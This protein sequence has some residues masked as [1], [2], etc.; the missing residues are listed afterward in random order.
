MVTQLA[1]AV[2]KQLAE[3]MLH[4]KGP[5]TEHDYK[6]GKETPRYV[7]E[8]VYPELP[9]DPGPAHE[10]SADDVAIEAAILRIGEAARQFP[11]FEKI[12]DEHVF[13]QVVDAG[14]LRFTIDFDHGTATLSRGWDASRPPT[15]VLPV[16]RLN[17][18]NMEEVLRDGTLTYEELYRIV[19]VL[20][21]AAVRRMYSIPMLKEP[22]DKSWIGMDDFVHVVIP[23]TEPVIYQDRPIRVELT[24]VN[25]DGQWLVMQGLHGDPD[26]RF[27]LTLDDAARWYKF[28]VYDLPKVKGTGE[29]LKV[30]S[31]VAAVTKK[32]MT[33]LRAEH[34]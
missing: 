14:N 22:G 33:Y 13:V 34:R 23:P 6:S 12:E 17:L 25:V 30:A 27:D 18:A 10:F 8:M 9:I 11:W 1:S 4:F 19:Y 3:V 21:P 5:T 31:D 7:R 15:L 20:A 29:L 28:A 16:N 26:A 32:T 24:V 2:F